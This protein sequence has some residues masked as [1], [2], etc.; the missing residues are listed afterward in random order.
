MG[1]LPRP[2][3]DKGTWGDILNDFLQE[4]HNS[5]GTLKDTGIL[6]TK[7]T[8]PSGGIPTSDLSTGVQA[9]LAN[10]DAAVT[11]TVPDAASSIKGKLK[12]A[13]DL[14][15]SAD[16]PVITT[17]AITASKIADNTITTTQ[18]AAAHLDGAAGTPSLRTLGTGASQAAAGNDSRITGAE[19]TSNRDTDGT[20][21]ANS[22][23]KYPTQRAAKTYVDAEATARTNADAAHVAAADPHTVYP[24]ADRLGKAQQR[25]KLSPLRTF[26]FRASSTKVNL[27]ALSTDVLVVGDSITEGYYGSGTDDTM[28]FGRFKKGITRAFNVDG[29]YGE[30][31][32]AGD[33]WY[34]QHRF[35]DNGSASE[36]NIGISLRARNMVSGSPDAVSSAMLTDRINVHYYAANVFGQAALTYTITDAFTG[37]TVVGPTRLATYDSSLPLNAGEA[38]VWDSGA[39]T[40]GYYKLTVKWDGQGAFTGAGI[41]LGAYFCDGDYN[42]GVRCWN[43]SHYGYAWQA[44]TTNTT[45]FLTQIVKGIIKP[46]LVVFAY[47]TNDLQTDPTGL[48]TRI[49]TAVANMNAACT[50]AGLVAPSIAF[51]VPPANATKTDATWRTN[52]IDVIYTCAEAAG[53]D[54]WEWAELTGSVSNPDGADPLDIV[55]DSTHPNDYGQ[56]MIGD[57]AAAQGLKSLS[58]ILNTDMTRKQLLSGH[59]TLNYVG[60][61]TSGTTTLDC[62]A[63][64]HHHITLAGNSTIAFSGAVA[65]QQDTIDLTLLQD[66]TGSRTVTWPGSVTWLS[67]STPT[68][69]TAASAVDMFH[70]VSYDGGTHWYGSQLGVGGSSGTVADGSIGLVKLDTTVNGLL[71][72]GAA[73]TAT[74]RT[75]GTGSTNAAP[76]DRPTVNELNLPTG[77]IWASHDMG[78]A[79]LAATTYPLATQGKEWLVQVKFVKPITITRIGLWCSTAFSG[80]T[81][82]FAGITNSSSVVQAISADDTSANISVGAAKYWTLGTPF[83][84]SAGVTYYFYFCLN[85]STVGGIAGLTMASSTNMPVL[86]GAVVSAAAGAGSITTPP[87]VGATIG[88]RTAGSNVV[89]WVLIQ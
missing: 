49:N 11:G 26:N 76:G 75:L 14:T 83:N 36:L 19:Q 67:G 41:W 46:S 80:G 50:G 78:T 35:S 77:A 16:V 38:R 72:E 13:G 89:P 24:N 85:F 60:P 1:R 52:G 48:A 87:A 71:T 29:R 32:A 10:A 74:I 7:Y 2:G 64:Q 20:L 34:P 28:W 27:V 73:G 62:S 47:G 61:V 9:S 33:G 22:D 59:R 84:A 39:L 88:A 55:F 54:V 51:M 31:I 42:K 81:H 30:W 23:T 3:S 25:H 65:T 6:A 44:L 58:S 12:L 79:N 4:S 68:L 45:G 17:G 15:G 69:K 57:F 86:V 37:A 56:A 5:D 53:A 82:S 63:N 18:I 40:R 43:G 8:V 21:A 70:F 66:S